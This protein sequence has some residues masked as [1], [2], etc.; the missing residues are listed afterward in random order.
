MARCSK[1]YP[2]QFLW[3]CMGTPPGPPRSHFVTSWGENDSEIVILQTILEELEKPF[4]DQKE[5][6][7]RQKSHED[8]VGKATS[9]SS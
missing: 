6:R 7:P 3:N 8:P 5:P 9:A 2:M 4:S 1:A